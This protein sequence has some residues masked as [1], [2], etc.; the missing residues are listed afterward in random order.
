LTFG[1]E[2]APFEVLAL[3]KGVHES[4]PWAKK[5]FEEVLQLI[6]AKAGR[7]MEEGYQ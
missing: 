1:Y 4:H 5:M 2:T 6:P 7:L 3:E